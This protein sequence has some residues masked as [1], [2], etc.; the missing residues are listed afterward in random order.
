MSI[1]LPRSHRLANRRQ[2]ALHVLRL[3]VADGGHCDFCVS[4]YG[5]DHPWPCLPARIAMLYMGK[6]QH[7]DR[8]ARPGDLAT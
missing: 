1:P 6:P 7:G 3:H 5:A 2:W 8:P 4:T